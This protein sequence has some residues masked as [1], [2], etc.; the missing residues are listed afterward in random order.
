MALRP[1]R[2]VRDMNKVAWT[3]FSRSKPRKSYIKS[4]PHRHLNQ[5]AMG[6]KK[7][8]YN[9]VLGL[10]AEEDVIV[11]DNSLESARQAVNRYL[12]K[13]AQGNYY[14]VVVQY[15]HHVIREN[16]MVATAGADRIQQGMRRSFGKPTSRAA[17]IYKGRPVFI[18]ST[19]KQFLEK[20]K[21]SLLKAPKKMSGAYKV[22]VLPKVAV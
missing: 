16:R 13:T 3:R 19:Y 12:E 17:R 20:A 5:F 21:E 4:L 8:D 1:A 18:V 9:V 7:S 15:P 11:R 22:K 14:L 2:C 10:V 6:T